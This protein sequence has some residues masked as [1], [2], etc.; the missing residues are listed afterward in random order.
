MPSISSYLKPLTGG[1][2]ISI[3]SPLKN[4]LSMNTLIMIVVVIVFL[5]IGVYVY[6]NYFSKAS[7][8][9]SANR[10]FDQGS[11]GG[12]T[13][14]IILFYVDWCPHCKTAKPIWEQVKAEY[15]N[16]T[17]KGYNVTFTEINCTNES[18]DITAVVDKYKIEGYPTIK[19]LKGDQV[20]DFEA[21]PTVSTLTQF[22]NA[23]L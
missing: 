13:A 20:I 10:E 16:K 8:L 11:K 15:S 17:V 2:P 21:K 3:T 23:A 22:L 9:Y 7:K 4:G 18:P 5:G 6:M 1:S 14:E 19:L 12:A